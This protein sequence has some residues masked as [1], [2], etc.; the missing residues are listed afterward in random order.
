MNMKPGNF[1]EGK[2][3]AKKIYMSKLVK[4]NLYN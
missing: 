2:K 1:I 4:F 3:R